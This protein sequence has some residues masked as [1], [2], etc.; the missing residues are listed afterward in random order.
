[1]LDPTL[2]NTAIAWPLAWYCLDYWLQGFAFRITLSPLYFLTVGVLSSP[3]P[4][5]LIFSH[6]CAL[7]APIPSMPCAMSRARR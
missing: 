7:L 3:L 1:M 2:S 4:G 5:P 6:A